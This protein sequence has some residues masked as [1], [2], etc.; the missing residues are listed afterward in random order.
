MFTISTVPLYLVHCRLE[1]HGLEVASEGLRLG[2]LQSGED[3]GVILGHLPRLPVLLARPLLGLHEDN[4]LVGERLL[5][6]QLD[7][8]RCAR[9][10]RL[11][12]RQLP[13]GC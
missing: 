2:A 5:Q 1:V 11:L 9:P 12:T 8:L 6:P 13:R 4:L 10:P 3:R 7:P